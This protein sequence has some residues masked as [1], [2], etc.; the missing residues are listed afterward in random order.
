MHINY[1]D[2]AENVWFRVTEYSKNRNCFQLFQ[3][4]QLYSAGGLVRLGVLVGG[5]MKGNTSWRTS[6]GRVVI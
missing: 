3:I 1:R 6:Q 5:G 2:F 4:A